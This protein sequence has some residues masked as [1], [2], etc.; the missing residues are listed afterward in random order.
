[1]CPCLG[2]LLLRGRCRD[3]GAAISARY[4]IVEAVMGLVFF[5]LAYVELFSGGANLPGGPFIEEKGAVAVVL[6][7]QWG[8]IGLF[9]YHVALM[10]LLTAIALIAWDGHR[11]PRLLLALAILG[12]I[13][14]TLGAVPLTG[15]KRCEVLDS[16]TFLDDLVDD[17]RTGLVTNVSPPTRQSEEDCDGRRLL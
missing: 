13:P 8:I 6:E 9:A 11:V 14:P 7:P 5:L 2:W 4:A 3:C 15:G 1:M 16:A 10:A 12:L 17:L